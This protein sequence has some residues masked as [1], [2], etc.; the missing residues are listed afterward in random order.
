MPNDK[1]GNSKRYARRDEC[2]AS[3]RVRVLDR[4]KLPLVIARAKLTGCLRRLGRIATT[5]EIEG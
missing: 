4:Q 2:A 3:L 5:S 1:G